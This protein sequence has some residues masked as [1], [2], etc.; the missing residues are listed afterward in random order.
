MD[1]IIKYLKTLNK[2]VRVEV[3]F[4]KQ[5]F[6]GEITYDVTVKIKDKSGYGI[7]YEFDIDKNTK[8]G[9]VKKNLAKALRLK[10]K[11]K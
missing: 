5:E 7:T 8:L 3:E 1:K 4:L 10:N 9:F 6:E 2:R 11:R